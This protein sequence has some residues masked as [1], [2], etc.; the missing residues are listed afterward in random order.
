M[1][2][3][4]A[5]GVPARPLPGTTLGMLGDEG[6]RLFFPLSALYAALFPALWVFGWGFDLPFATTVPPSIW[7]AHEMLI[8]AFGAAL[9]GFMTTAVPEWTDTQPP[10]GRPLWY[11]AALWG[12]GRAIGVLGWDGLGGLGAI[13]DLTWIG[14]LLVW[15]LRLSWRRQTDRLVAFAFWLLLLGLCTGAARIGFFMGDLALASTGVHLAG[16]AFL[17]LLGLVL[18]RVTV[19]VTNLVLDPTERRSPFRPHPGRLHLAPGLV[20]V[21]MVGE[22]AGLSPAV[23]GFLFLAAGAAFV[24]RVAEGFVGWSAA[25]TEILMLA[26]SSLLAGAGLIL[27]GSARLGAPWSEITGLHVAFMGGLGLGVFAVFSIAGLL[28]ANRP[29]GIPAIA[30]IGAL[31]LVSSTVLRVLPDF[32]MA[33]PGPIHGLAVIGWTLAFLLWIA[34]Y[35]PTLSASSQVR[36]VA[37]PGCDT[38]DSPP[39]PRR[40]QAAE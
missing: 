36:Q 21:A 39:N 7:H 20:L 25:R 3:G 33:L 34:A 32:G 28:H 10:R 37:T 26:G 4:P 16:F 14:A 12:I 13:A 17:G 2:C 24:D 29:L 15:I 35:W 40:R 8:G 11:F 1:S 9:I 30:R 23:A 5:S 6:F 27:A 22:A 19:P 18:A 38:P 31:A